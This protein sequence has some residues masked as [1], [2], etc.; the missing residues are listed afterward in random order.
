[1]RTEILAHLHSVSG[2]NR[3][4]AGKKPQAEGIRR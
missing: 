1:L 2:E 4:G 3:T